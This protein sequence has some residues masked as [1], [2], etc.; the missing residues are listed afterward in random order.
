M[1][2]GDRV[3]VFVPPG[4]VVRDDRRVPD[5][6]GDVGRL[7]VVER[8]QDLALVNGAISLLRKEHDH[9]QV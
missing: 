3:K 8:D 7:L 2:S 4:G 5:D 9:V 1:D 6:E